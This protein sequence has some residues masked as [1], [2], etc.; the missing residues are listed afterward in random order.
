MNDRIATIDNAVSVA[1]RLKQQEMR[2]AQQQRTARPD[3]RFP[4]T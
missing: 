4:K 3:A 1:V 2:T